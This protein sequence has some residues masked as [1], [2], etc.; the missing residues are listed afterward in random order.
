M[1]HIGIGC[2]GTL[3]SWGMWNEKYQWHD[4][5]FDLYALKSRPLNLSCVELRSPRHVSSQELVYRNKATVFFFQLPCINTLHLY[6]NEGGG[7][8]IS[9]SESCGTAATDA[10]S[11]ILLGHKVELFIGPR[12]CARHCICWQKIYRQTLYSL[13]IITDHLPKWLINKAEAKQ[14]IYLYGS[15]DIKFRVDGLKRIKGPWMS[16]DGWLY[17]AAMKIWP[18]LINLQDPASWSVLLVPSNRVFPPA[19]LFFNH[20]RLP[21]S[22]VCLA[23]KCKWLWAP[24][25]SDGRTQILIC[26]VAHLCQAYSVC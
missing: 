9:R 25:M 4:L 14:I 2:E 5:W 1:L 19:F 21:S 11:A 20:S 8:D 17:K 6:Q 13:M 23:A 7:R 16:G 18:F 3:S 15:V 26:Q 22:G 12:P 10:A 24:Q